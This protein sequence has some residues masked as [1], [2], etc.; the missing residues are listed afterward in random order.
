MNRI[1]LIG[2]LTAKPELRATSNGT[3][4]CRFTIAVNRPRRED[5]T[6]EADFINCTVWNKQAENLTMYQDKGNLISVEGNLRVD[7]YT[8]KDGNKRSLTYVLVERI[9]FLESKKSENKVEPVDKEE[10]EDPFAN[11]GDI[12]EEQQDMDNFL[13]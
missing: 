3:S 12:V 4:V 13:E 7:N 1:C 11:F 5:G 2:R 10:T 9:G 8:D 6:Q